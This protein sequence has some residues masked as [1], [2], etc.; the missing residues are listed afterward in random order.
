MRI[1]KTQDCTY[2]VVETDS[3]GQTF[4][5]GEYGTFLEAMESIAEWEQWED[6]WERTEGCEDNDEEI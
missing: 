4:A 1:Q 6:E 5:F 2:L 3:D